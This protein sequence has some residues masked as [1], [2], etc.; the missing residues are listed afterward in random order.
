MWRALQFRYEDKTIQVV[1]FFP[2]E[3]KITDTCESLPLPRKPG[4]EEKNFVFYP[5]SVAFPISKWMLRKISLRDE[6]VAIANYVL[7]ENYYL[8]RILQGLYSKGWHLGSR[9]KILP[10]SRNNR[11]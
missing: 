9:H 3:L 6:L 7:D 4:R 5:L 2:L 11:G 10:V 8:Y 1:S